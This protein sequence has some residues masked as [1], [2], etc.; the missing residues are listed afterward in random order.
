MSEYGKPLPD[1]DDPLTA[2]FWTAARDGELVA[3]RCD[4]CGYLRW[5]PGPVCTECL[6][7][8]G[9]WT[10]IRPTGRLWSIAEYHRALSPAF[11]DD[12]PYTV[13]FVELDDGPRMYGTMVGEAGSFA[14]DQ[15]VDALFV[16]VTPTIT[17][18][19]WEIAARNAHDERTSP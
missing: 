8:G 6:A 4:R 7:H 3:Q 17:L 13:G 10:R 2:T 18:V 9:T 12:L 11:R 15:R 19:H 16:P 5:P 14:P 1:P